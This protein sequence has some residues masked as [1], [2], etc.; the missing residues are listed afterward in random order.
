MRRTLPSFCP[1]WSKADNRGEEA[2]RT[3]DATLNGIDHIQRPHA[4]HRTHEEAV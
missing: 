2:Q 4:H 1:E 3:A